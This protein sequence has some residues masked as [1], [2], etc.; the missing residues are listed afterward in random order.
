[1]DT[2]E[3]RLNALNKE[4]SDLQEK[5]TQARNQLD[6]VVQQITLDESF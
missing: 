3:D 4:I 5:Q 2:Q 1:L 6:Q